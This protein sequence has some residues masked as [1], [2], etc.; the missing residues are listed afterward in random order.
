VIADMG[1]FYLIRM[2]NELMKY[3]ASMPLKFDR[4][5]SGVLKCK[6]FCTYHQNDFDILTEEKKTIVAPTSLQKFYTN[7]LRP[8]KVVYPSPC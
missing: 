7:R 4:W 2:V 6:A 5:E 3:E 8:Y 1:S